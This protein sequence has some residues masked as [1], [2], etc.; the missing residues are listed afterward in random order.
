MDDLS[1]KVA[2]VT[3]AASGIGRATALAFARE[4]AG[5]LIICD[6]DG[7]GLAGAASEIEHIGSEA[8]AFTTDVS[9]FGEVESMAREALGKI[10]R[11][12]VLANVAG[13]GVM[14]PI[15]ALDMDDWRAV[16]GVNLFGAIH[17]VQAVFPHMAERRSGHIVNVASTDGLFVPGIYGL[18]YFTSKFGLVGFTEGLML[19]ASLYDIGVSCVCPS[20]TKTPMFDTVPVKGFRPEVRKLARL[21]WH[22]AG[23]PEDVA[24]AIVDAVKKDKF[25]VLTTSWAKA[26]YYR[27]RHSP[28]AWF[29]ARKRSASRAAR[30]L[31]KYRTISYR[32]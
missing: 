19:E 26:A 14:A 3:G 32:C 16:M 31:D 5:P 27:R 12:D 30:T 17:T 28:S 20:V 23:T 6:V 15:E 8:L 22:V 21:L 10:G 13:I 11:I 25:L 29:R 2:L 24:G 7:G 18:P 9:D 4:G 1:G